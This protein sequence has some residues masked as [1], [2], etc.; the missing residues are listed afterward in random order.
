MH[1]IKKYRF[2]IL[3]LLIA[4][5]A[6]S[7]IF[8]NAPA[9]QEK[10]VSVKVPKV[11]YSLVVISDQP[12]PVFSRGRVSASEVRQ[13]TTE[14]PGLVKQVSKHLKK[15][16]TV[17]QHDLLIQ[18]DEQPFILEVAQRQ[19]DLDRVKLELV[20]IEAQAKVA[21]KDLRSNATEYAR[22]IPQVRHAKSQVAAAESALS[23]SQKKLEKTTIS[24]PIDGKVVDL[25]VT[26]GEYINATSSIA[27][28]YGTHT[29]DVRLPLND[30]Q[31]DIL[32]LA[33]ESDFYTK[34]NVTGPRVTLSNYQDKESHWEGFISRVEGERDINQLIYVIAQVS[35]DT[36]SNAKQKPLLPGS[37]VEAM[38]EGENVPNLQIIP[39]NAE[40]ASNVIWLIDENNQLRR[41][42]IDIIYRGKDESYLLEGLNNNDRIV[43]GSFSL[44]AEGLKVQP[45]L[46]TEELANQ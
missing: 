30:Q 40:Q 34:E 35:I 17:K 32:D 20:R 8:I 25:M 13:I 4:S 43:T 11:P 33:R 21:Q 12:I 39:R 14:V 18:L 44:M 36:P 29:V 27:R 37:F 2:I 3:T 42:V 38:I 45:Y 41:K 26:E 9:P 10:P 46:A 16:A 1:L 6:I 7:W 28:I 31:I 24:S 23:Y 19:A 5:V 15:G 22:H